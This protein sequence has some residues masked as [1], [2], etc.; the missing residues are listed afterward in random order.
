MSKIFALV[1]DYDWFPDPKH[2]GIKTESE[3][4]KDCRYTWDV[5]AVCNVVRFSMF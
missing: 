4:V 3:L 1:Q 2:F 5:L